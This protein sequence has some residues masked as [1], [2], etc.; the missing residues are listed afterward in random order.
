MDAPVSALT[1]TYGER[2]QPKLTEH[3]KRRVVPMRCLTQYGQFCGYC[4]LP[5]YSNND[6][7][8]VRVAMSKAVEPPLADSVSEAQ[9]GVALVVPLT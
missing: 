6:D 7:R 2:R 8:T 4:G 9:M 1:V 3:K 5:P